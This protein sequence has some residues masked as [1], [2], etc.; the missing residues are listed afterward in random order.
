MADTNIVSFFLNIAGAAALLIWSVRLVRTG[1]ERAFSVQLRK[2][3][4]RSSSNRML[5]TSTGIFSAMLLQ[6]STAVAIMTSNFVAAGNISAV[7]GL[8]ILLGADIGSALVVQVLLV[9]QGFLIPLLLL[10]GVGLFLRGEQRRVRQSG[11]ILIGLALIFVSLDMIRAATTPLMGDPGTASVMAY[12]GSDMLTAFL[13]G[14]AFA[15]VVHSSVAAILLFVTL[16][17][18]G[19]MPQSAAV[20]MVLGA[21]LGGAVIAYV[22]TLSAPIDARRMVLANLVLRGGAAALTMLVLTAFHIPLNWIGATDARQII[23]LHLVFNVGLTVLALPIIGPIIRLMATFVKAPNAS[24]NVGRISALDHATLSSPERALVCATREIIHIGETIEAM[25]RS[26]DALYQKWDDAAAKGIADSDQ[27]V[28][29]LHFELKLFL[30]KLAHEGLDEDNSRKIMEISNIAVNL[31]SAADIIARNM[32]DLTK[33]L[34]RD[35]V[36]FSTDGQQEISDF[37]DRVLANA[38]LALHV[39]MTHN[40]DEARELVAEKEE[41]RGLEQDLQRKH[42]TRLQDGL[43][44]SIATSNIHQETLRALKQINTAFS[45]V[46]HPILAESG[47]LLESRLSSRNGFA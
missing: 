37:H 11:R 41:I 6:S 44:E 38:Q 19:L 10:V 7:V 8:A 20:A 16:V 30:A 22:L 12:L 14:A 33:Q 1:V 28:R 17:A 39:I 24:I 13:I 18:Q 45:M 36:R 25:L 27:Q 21:N 29:K 15:W 4:R 23:N 3:L 42:L 35:S 26:I 40:P 32:I 2:W 31:E 9:R 34:D 46:A 43:A 5:A 47:E